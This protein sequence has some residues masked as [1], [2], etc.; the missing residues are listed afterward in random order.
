MSDTLYITKVIYDTVF[1]KGADYIDIANKIDSMY[2]NSWNRLMAFFVV[3]SIGI[4]L[5]ITW[6]LGREL[7]RSNKEVQKQIDSLEIKG[8]R[9]NGFMAHM[10]GEVSR[11]VSKDY[12]Q[13]VSDYL[14]AI[15]YYI[16]AKDDTSA[17][18]CLDA[19]MHS[20]TFL[21]ADEL[22]AISIRTDIR[23]DVNTINSGVPASLRAD[24]DKVR[25]AIRPQN[26]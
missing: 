12:N 5:L 10:Q 14:K 2:N 20:L 13:A 25:A 7:R 19:L 17:S 11:L 1:I 23:T 22:K 24:F 4:P 16:K 21:S 9:S 6:I 26:L 8:E 18:R 3:L 15:K